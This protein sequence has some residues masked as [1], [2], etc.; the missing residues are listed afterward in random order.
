MLLDAGADVNIQSNYGFTPL[1][2]AFAKF[3]WDLSD[4][5]QILLNIASRKK[6]ICFFDFS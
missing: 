3:A 5:N 4:G 2:L 6:M 1:F